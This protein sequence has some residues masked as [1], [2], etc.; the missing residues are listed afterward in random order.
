MSI[1]ANAIREVVVA[2]GGITGW[3]AAAALKRRLPGL[4]V[5]MVSVPPPADALADR[6][7]STLPSILEFHRDIGL[8]DA[9]AVV[10][11]GSSFR[12][13][14]CFEGWAADLPSYVHAYGEYGRPFGTASFHLHWV[15]A[16]QRRSAAAFDS[17]SPAAAI[18]R[19]GR[20]VQPQG[21][22]GSPLAGFEYRLQLNLPRY[23]EMMRAYALHLGVTERAAGIAGVRLRGEDGFVEALALD[24]GSEVGGHLFVDCTG[25]AATLHSALDQDFEAWD[26]WLP[27]DRILFAETPPPPEPTALDTVVAMPAGWRW[28]AA[29][30]I[31]TAHGLVYASSYLGDGE[32]EAALRGAA[33]AEPTAPPVTICAGR[34]AQPW[35]RNCVA[36]G[37]SAVAMEPLEWGNLHLAHS[38]IDRLVSMMP[39]RDCGAVELWD[40]NRQS[41]SEADR[42][43]DFLVLHY[44]AARRPEPF[45]QAAAAAEPPAS[46]AHTL[47]LF[48]ERGRLPIYEEETFSRDSWLAVLL[49]QG[50]IPERTDPLID[51]LSPTQA[52]QAMAK[53]REAIAA[54]VPTLPTHS[55]YLRNLSRQFAR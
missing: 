46:L 18:A 10:R 34:R 31:R 53:M 2:G 15:R 19:A 24:D 33:G 25:P 8:G 4:T 54:I 36:I 7:A 28:Q 49:G 45:W 22:E 9:D 40:Y 6:I 38:G 37:D 16:A 42:M 50:V 48:R 35:L 20:F 30:A 17:H 14:T 1:S 43:R 12:L 11:A 13:G 51:S 26:R 32:A 27:C 47:S 39:D 44:V 29:S 5:T 3:S 21:E 41:A 55:A 52:D 23:R